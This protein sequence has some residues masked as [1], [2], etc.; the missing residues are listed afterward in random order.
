MFKRILNTILALL[1]FFSTT[2]FTVTNHYCGSYL[3][4]SSIFGSPENC[5]NSDMNCCHNES[6]TIKIHDEYS[7]TSF[8]HD[9]SQKGLETEFNINLIFQEITENYTKS[10]FPYKVKPHKIKEV[11][12]IIQSYLL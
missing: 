12:S 6:F 7:L 5:C 10:N 8:S 3:N 4:S 11:L 1:L 2:G 9:F